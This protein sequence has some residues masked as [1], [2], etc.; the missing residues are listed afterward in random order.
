MNN[1]LL[2]QFYKNN[3]L[4]SYY[5]VNPLRPKSLSVDDFNE[6]LKNRT[7]QDE[8]ID[9]IRSMKERGVPMFL[10]SYQG[11]TKIRRYI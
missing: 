2:N 6:F 3:K 1:L 9:R 10:N 4:N 5:S 7:P 8:E 11:N